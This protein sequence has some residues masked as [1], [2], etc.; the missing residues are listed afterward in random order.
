MSANH[1]RPT[2]RTEF[3]DE[4]R[5]G[6]G[7]AVDAAIR[8]ARDGTIA[9]IAGGA[10]L[11]RAL[12]ASSRRRRLVQA[13]AGLALVG[14]GLRQRL[15]GGGSARDRTS[16]SG[17]GDGPRGR[18]HLEGPPAGEPRRDRTAE[19]V[20]GEATADDGVPASDE[21]PPEPD[22]GAAPEPDDA[23]AESDVAEPGPDDVGSES[24]EEASEPDD[25]ATG[26]ES[27]ADDGE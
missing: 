2:E 27:S 11:A 24:T 1:S 14:V 23:G 7:G 20:E 17:G 4:P 18:S 16:P 3:D 8:R 6:G 13:L 26:D 25:V 22:E 10:L 19:D 15:A 5:T 12:R 21:A 9:A